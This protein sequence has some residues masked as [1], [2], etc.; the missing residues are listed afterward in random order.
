MTTEPSATA[1]PTTPERGFVRLARANLAAQT[2][3]Q[4]ALAAAPII[5]VVSLGATESDTGWLQTAQTLP[6]LLLSIPA[7]LLVDRLQPRQ[8]MAVAE[9]LRALAMAVLVVLLLSGKL[10]L[11][12]LALLGFVAASATVAFTVAAPALVP[13]LVLTQRLG[14]ANGRLELARTIAY[15]LG[16]ALAGIMIARLG[17]APAFVV[18]AVLSA[19]AALLLMRLASVPRTV[20]PAPK[21]LQQIAEGARFVIGHDLLRPIFITQFV[22]GVAIFMLQAVYVP[23]AIRHL[24]M[25]TERVGFTLAAYGAGMIVGASLAARVVALLPRRIA[26]IHWVID[27]GDECRVIGAQKRDHIGN[28]LS[29]AKPADRVQIDQVGMTRRFR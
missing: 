22:F 12:W 24:Q 14:W 18:T 23:Y 9:A 26:S 2:A 29:V 15:A 10:S 6:F 5:A 1:F 13:A 25:S 17:A 4:I 7:G 11:L 28:V 21:P 16:P 27:A 3:E 19:S 8:V 20:Q